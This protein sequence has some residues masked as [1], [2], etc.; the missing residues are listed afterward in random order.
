MRLPVI[1]ALVAA[2]ALGQPPTPPS[3]PLDS[4]KLPA[5]FRI[6][7]YASGVQA[8]RELAVG[9]KNTVFAGSMRG[10]VYAI[11]DADGDHRGDRVITIARGLNQ[12]SGVAFRDGPPYV[13]AIHRMTRYD[14]IATQLEKPAPPVPA[15]DAF[16]GD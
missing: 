3:L 4:L 2:F 10:D 1:A 15:S 8:V 5:G 12:P 6:D 13:A 9:T 14:N 16:P 11:V 7:L